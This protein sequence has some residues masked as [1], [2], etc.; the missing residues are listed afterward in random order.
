[1]RGVSVVVLARGRHDHLRRTLCS[2]LAC[3]PPP[4]EVVVVAMAVD[5]IPV[6]VRKVTHDHET[7]VADTNGPRSYVPTVRSV[8]LDADPRRLPLARA[9]NLGARCA[10]GDRLVFLDVDCLAD[11]RLIGAYD[12]AIGRLTAGAASQGRGGPAVAAGPSGPAVAADPVT[13]LPED[14]RELTRPDESGAIDPAGLHA[15]RAPHAARP[16]PAPGELVEG[17][18]P[19]LFWSLSFAVT[20]ADFAA[21]G[22]LDE[23]YEGYG[24]EDTDFARRLFHA[25]GSL[26]WVGGADAY[27]QHHPVSRPPVEHL[28]DILRNAALFEDRWGEPCMTGWLEA[29][30]ELGLVRR[31]GP[32]RFRRVEPPVVHV[33]AGADTHGITRH[34]LDLLG[35]GDAEVLRIADDGGDPAARLAECAAQAAPGVALHVHLNDTPLGPDTVEAVVAAACRRRTTL[36]LHDLPD[37]REGAERYARRALG[38][39]RLWEASAGV[40]VASRHEAGLLR[41]TAERVGRSPEAMPPVSVVPLP[42]RE[43]TSYDGA[44]AG[45]DPLDPVVAVLGFLYPGKGHEQALRAA[46]AAGLRGVVALGAVSPGHESDAAAFAERARAAR[47][48]W[49]VTGFLPEGELLRRA[50]RVAVPLAW[51]AHVSASGSIGTWLQAGRRPLVA[52]GAWVREL[53]ERCPGS[54]TIVPDEQGLAAAVERAVA[55]P[56]STFLGPDVR[57]G[58]SPAEAWAATAESI[59]SAH[60][61]AEG[62]QP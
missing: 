61:A 37:P 7:Q 25:G 45:A 62:A 32:G 5:A 42:L 17:D 40:V 4:N 15:L 60:R 11:P 10:R 19:N 14:W 38:Y 33:V 18:D 29:F 52:D 47:L 21:I 6:L 22:G 20:T 3:D 50:R 30:E 39:A 44:P 27:H 43:P 28:D 23:A 41:T 49:E 54:V 35:H 12:D 31:D 13:Y 51:H 1:M 46:E 53:E 56:G 58:P 2:V 8:A 16:D 48:S 26:W 59:A 55:D 34:A 36:T 57:L 9:R 24:G